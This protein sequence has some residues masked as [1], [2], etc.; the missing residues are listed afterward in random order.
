MNY[1]ATLTSDTSNSV[2]TPTF[3]VYMNLKTRK[4]YDNFLKLNKKICYIILRNWGK[5]FCTWTVTTK[6]S[7]RRDDVNQTCRHVWNAAMGIEP[8]LATNDV[9]K[10]TQNVTAI[11]LSINNPPA[12]IDQI[13]ENKIEHK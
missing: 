7:A 2:V 11:T 5:K 8:S 4:K 13:I 10:V 1:V 3:P 12:I 6:L 9:A